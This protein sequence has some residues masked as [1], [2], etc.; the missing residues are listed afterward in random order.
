MKYPRRRINDEKEI[1]FVKLLLTDVILYSNND[2]E[3]RINVDE[4]ATLPPVPVD[5]DPWL[6]G[7]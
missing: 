7:G 3:G 4:P 6:T 1:D 2:E 5:E